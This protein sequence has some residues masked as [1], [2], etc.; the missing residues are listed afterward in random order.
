MKLVRT[1]LLA[2]LA[3]LVTGTALAGKKKEATP[4]ADAQTFGAP[5][6]VKKATPVAK[7]AK[8]PARLAGKKVRI[9]GTV[10]EVCQGKGCWIEVEADGASFLARS[11]DESVLVPKDCKGRAVVV[12]GVVKTLPRA[13]KA[14]AEA[15]AANPEG[16]ACPAPQWVLATEGVELR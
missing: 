9:Q 1:L 15:A 5:I 2:S 7:L 13:A 14:E 16:H 8:D 10:K 3:L 6:T 11:L 12:Q 4:S